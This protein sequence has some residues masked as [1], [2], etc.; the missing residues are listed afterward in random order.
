MA[1]HAGRVTVHHDGT[2]QG[3]GLSKAIADALHPSLHEQYGSER[4]AQPTEFHPETF[5]VMPE[6][7][8]FGHYAMT[9]MLPLIHAIADGVIAHLSE[10]EATKEPR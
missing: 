3:T 9:S 1:L 5:E 7:K 8:T 2:P 10:H 4:M 6:G